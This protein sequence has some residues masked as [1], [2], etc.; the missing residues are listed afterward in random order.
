MWTATHTTVSGLILSCVF[1][2]M[3]SNRYYELMEQLYLANQAFSKEWDAWKRD[4]LEGEQPKAVVDTRDKFWVALR[5]LFEAVL[6]P[7]R[8]RFK[9][10]SS[11]AVDEV[12]E[13]LAVDIPAFRCGYE[14]E[15][16]LHR[17][18][19]VPL[20][21]KQEQGL[22][23]IAYKLCSG[24]GYRRELAYAGRLVARFADLAFVQELQ[25]LAEGSNELVRVKA[26]RML[27][28]IFDE[29]A[30]LKKEAERLIS[31]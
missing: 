1:S 3:A 26:Q 28:I 2:L 8:E 6:D 21:E 31:A 29:R 7:L 27:I 16:Y 23:Q 5:H 12:I 20:S 13:F 9:A 30:D 18:K 22:L 17:L 14:K 19:S 25:K 11:Q 10:D 4:G 24:S 15:W